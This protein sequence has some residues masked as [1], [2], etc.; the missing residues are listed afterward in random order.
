MRTFIHQLNCTMACHF[1]W[2]LTAISHAYDSP[3]ANKGQTSDL[4]DT[5]CSWLWWCSCCSC[6]CQR[7]FGS[8]HDAWWHLPSQSSH[9]IPCPVASGK[10]SSMMRSQAHSTQLNSVLLSPGHHDFVDAFVKKALR[11]GS[12]TN[13]YECMTFRLHTSKSIKGFNRYHISLSI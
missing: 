1:L 7:V 11:F 10:G 8:S 2:I 6:T 9:R 4:G 5:H 12:A 3:H 13:N